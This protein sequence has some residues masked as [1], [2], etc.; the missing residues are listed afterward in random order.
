M[1]LH[2]IRVQGWRCFADPIEVGPFDER[3]NVLHAPNGTGKSK[4]LEALLRA[5]FDSHR[6]TG[7]DVEALRP[8]G[9]ALSPRVTVDFALGGVDYRLEKGFLDE[10]AT[11]L[12]RREDGRF[13]SL[14]EGD[15]ADDLVRELLLGSAPGRGVSKQTHWGLAQVLWAPQEGLTLP[16]LSDNIVDGIRHSLGAQMQGPE[17]GCL[18]R[19]IDEIYFEIYTP[20]GRLRGGKDAPRVVTLAE[21]LDQLRGQMQSVGQRLE[22]F[23]ETNRAVEDL[24]ARC[25]Q[26]QHD[27]RQLK[28]GADEARTAARTFA[29]LVARTDTLTAQVAA[30]AA[31]TEELARRMDRIHDLR[32][33]LEEIEADIRARQAD[34]PAIAAEREAGRATERE[35]NEAV[36]RARAAREEVDRAR[37]ELERARRAAELHATV[38]TEEVRVGKAVEDDL[39]LAELREQRARLIAPDAKNLKAI[40]RALQSRDTVRTQLDAALVSLEIEPTKDGSLEVRAGEH[41]GTRILAAGEAVVLR[42]SPAV[43]VVLAGVGRIR[44]SGPAEDVPELRKQ[45]ARAERTLAGLTAPFGTQDIEALEQQGEARESLERRIGRIEEH[46]A[47]LLED[48]TLEERQQTLG[49]ARAELGEILKEH[50]AW[51]SQPPDIEALGSAEAALRKRQRA[52]E[53]QAEVALQAARA[54]LAAAE[55]RWDEHEA[56]LHDA[57][58]QIERIGADLQ[59]LL[60]DG[61]KDAER[62]EQWNKARRAQ[63]RLA[64]TLRDAVAERAQYPGDPRRDLAQVE[65]QLQAAEAAERKLSDEERSAAGRLAQLA[66]EAPYTAMAQAEETVAC[67]EQAHAREVLRADAIKLLRDTIERLRAEAVADV[68]GPVE[69]RATRIL[70]RIAGGRLGRL[71]LTDRFEPQHVVPGSTDQGVELLELS[72]GEREQLHLSVRLALPEVLAAGERQLVVLDDVLTATDTPRLARIQTILE[73]AAEKLQ[74]LILTCHPE[75]YGGLTEAD[76]K[77]QP[78]SAPVAPE[79]AGSSAPGMGPVGSI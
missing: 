72:G 7:R 39:Q 14:A 73:E 28:Q 44:A 57:R 6:V 16:G 19:R 49:R 69:D 51:Q 4:L 33:K 75:R 52:D 58:R 15:R 40:R 47:T 74:V 77:L 21:R 29:D 54:V 22:Q 37:A 61:L 42:G 66:V 59:E 3:L 78:P 5:F 71:R 35:A 2:S 63:E 65:K 50:N 60:G 43:E 1:I 36:E 26:A 32:R 68:A 55:K 25:A 70:H 41:P 10:A 53:R 38:R 46:L 23:A 12:R 64:A 13:V 79:E 30:A 11:T 24:A 48:E 34:E 31:H 56:R 76:K 62:T 8:W 20:T 27:L 9:R 18:E 45:L 67:L 17:G